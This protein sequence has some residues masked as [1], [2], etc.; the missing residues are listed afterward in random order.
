METL[1]DIIDE[2]TEQAYQ[3]ALAWAQEGGAMRGWDEA[4]TRAACRLE[5]IELVT[6]IVKATN[7][8]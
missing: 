3:D 8:A 2:M 6:R 5:V 4:E 7:N 1:E